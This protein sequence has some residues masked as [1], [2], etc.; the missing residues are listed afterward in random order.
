MEVRSNSAKVSPVLVMLDYLSM[1]PVQLFEHSF[2]KI[3]KGLLRK[4][5][6]FPSQRITETT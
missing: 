5:N 2:W 6:S 4:I 1:T 3:S